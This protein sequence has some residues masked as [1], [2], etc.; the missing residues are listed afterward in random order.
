MSSA[1]CSGWN[2]RNICIVSSADLFRL[3][4]DPKA[5]GEE[6]F[7][8]NKFHIEKDPTVIECAENE[9]KR[10]NSEEFHRDQQNQTTY[11]DLHGSVVS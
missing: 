8:H 10:R 9:L 11:G 6:V 4:F 2:V 1:I 7:F 5:P 3:K